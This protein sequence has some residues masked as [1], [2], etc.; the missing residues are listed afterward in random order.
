MVFKSRYLERYLDEFIKPRPASLPC[1]P[2]AERSVVMTEERESRIDVIDDDND[3]AFLDAEQEQAVVAR[4]K[5]K[6]RRRSE[7][8]ASH[9]CRQCGKV[10]KDGIWRHLHP[11]P[12][13]S[14]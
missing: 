11:I 1:T 13:P 10:Y 6:R 4:P 2:A 5:R 9:R 7:K 14:I 3:E 8:P 12:T